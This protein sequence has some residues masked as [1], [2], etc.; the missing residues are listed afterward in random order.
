VGNVANGAQIQPTRIQIQEP[1]NCLQLV[2]HALD[3]GGN[4]QCS[5]PLNSTTG[6]F[7]NS[8]DTTRGWGVT[9][10]FN[11]G[12]SMQRWAFGWLR[13]NGLGPWF[14]MSLLPSTSWVSNPP[15]ASYLAVFP[16]G[17]FNSINAPM[18][19]IDWV[20]FWDGAGVLNDGPM[21]S[22]SNN[23]HIL[24]ITSV[25][26]SLSSNG[27]TLGNVANYATPSGAGTEASGANTDN[28]RNQDL[29]VGSG[30]GRS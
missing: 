7:F 27:G 28:Q 1:A 22:G 12:A 10:T 24:A 5:Y 26:L 18:S 25:N 9:A 23:A 17:G 30:N 4:Y 6:A 2:W 20:G 11:G 3:P 8:T 13:I 21:G 14:P 19:F 29:L 15:N 16:F